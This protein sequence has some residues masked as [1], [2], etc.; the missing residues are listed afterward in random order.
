MTQFQRQFKQFGWNVTF[1]D[2]DDFHG[3]EASI[4]PK[5]KAIF[6]EAIANPGGL[7]VD[8]ERLAEIAHRHG[9]PLIVD[10]TT[11]TPYLVRPFEFGADVVLYSATKGLG[12]HGNAM[13]G[14]LVERG[15]FDWGSGKFPVLSE[16]CDSYNGIRLYDVFGKDGPVAEMLG[17]KGK[18]GI[19]FAIAA[20]TLGLRDMGM[21]MS[22]FN[23]FLINMG[24]ETLPLRIQ[25]ASDNALVVATFLTK[26]EKVGWV[27]YG[28]LGN[29][30]A[31]KELLMKYSPNGGGSLF[32]FGLKGGFD[33]GKTLVD[34][35]K[36]IS[37]VANLGDSRTLIAHPSSMMHSQLSEEQRQAAGAEVETIR[38]S[39]GYEDAKDIIADLSQALDLV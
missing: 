11:A 32:T 34:S 25:K 12:G 6:C 39:V 33:A 38:L 20:R 23:A 29:D 36:M 9:L 2:E 5:T 1:C 24:M 4:G 26:H 16:P 31:Q 28:A 3:I 13:G 37:L 17:T 19:S 10:N 21:C 27:R 15:D 35:V 22:P 18:A 30:A 14:F 7:M 8:L